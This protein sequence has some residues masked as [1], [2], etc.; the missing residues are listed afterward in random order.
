VAKKTTSTII[1]IR[2]D[3]KDIKRKLDQVN[4]NIKGSQ[5]QVAQSSNLMSRDFKKVAISIA[6]VTVVAAKMWATF[7]NPSI[8]LQ[9]QMANVH[10]LTDLSTTSLVRMTEQVHDL[11]TEIPKAAPELAAGLYQVVSAGV[12]ASN[13]LN[14]LEDSAKAATAGVASTTQALELGAAVIKAYGKDW[15]DFESIQD[16]AFKT[17]ELGQTTF[18]Q[19]GS[20]IQRVAAQSA[21]LKIRTEEVFGAFATLT[22]VTGS[23]AEV[24][25]QLRMILTGLI[26]PKKELLA[27]I[28]DTEFATVEEMVQTK[29]LIGTLDF[30]K[31]AT[32]GQ[33]AE[34]GKMFESAESITALLALMG[35]Q[36]ETLIE[37][38][39]EITNSTGAMNDAFEKQMNTFE[40]QVKILANKFTPAL[41]DVTSWLT[42]GVIAANEFMNSITETS[43]ERTIKELKDLGVETLDYEL[44]IAKFR[45]AQAKLEAA[46]LEDEETIKKRIVEMEK[47]RIDVITRLAEEQTSLVESGET[48]E[49]L[50]RRIADWQSIIAL[51]SR[52]TGV[53]VQKTARAS[54]A[55]AEAKLSAVESTRAQR[56]ELEATLETSKEELVLVEKQRLAK[57]QVAAIEGVIAEKAKETKEELEGQDEAAGDL[58]P[59]RRE[60]T[61]EEK[62]LA[63]FA[64]ATSASLIT[65]AIAGDDLG[66]SLK[67]AAIQL[68]IMVVQAR[69]YNAL[70]KSATLGPLGAIAGFL[71][72]HK[73]G[74]IMHGGGGIPKMHA[75]GMRPDER[76]I[77][78][79]TGEFM[80]KREAV[81]GIGQSNLEEMNRTGQVPPGAGGQQVLNF[82]KLITTQEF[83]QDHIKPIMDE[84]A[85]LDLS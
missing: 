44:A 79:Q 55:D 65:S 61:A 75:G 19:L 73:G 17:V 47:E 1:E 71:G 20:G 46:G 74:L 59:S 53:S 69:I 56:D 60:A 85:D 6:A 2:G 36:Y 34:L 40:N 77:I 27:L 50:K 81:R 8:E 25:T 76:L 18:G 66:D 63:H 52:E 12:D 70:M 7:I 67:R 28:K 72:F 54:I 32:G 78:G 21:T 23:T 31:E 51:G 48:E 5:K 42:Q 80:L 62:K 10:T 82:D 15:Q 64:A 38:T 39:D 30:L 24:S 58:P 41:I 22:G 26:K 84:Q 3:I 43:L 68:A 49:I 4:A 33:A 16:Q 13:Q 57:E 29:G 9:T 37:K 35:P 14:V 83:Y 11:S 45:K